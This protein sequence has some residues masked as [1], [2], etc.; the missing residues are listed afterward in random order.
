MTEQLP[1]KPEEN[2]AAL[3]LPAGDL[4]PAKSLQAPKLF[5]LVRDHGA[6]V[7]QVIDQELKDCAFALD[8]E[9][10]DR[11]RRI[12]TQ[13]LVEV[14]SHDTLVDIVR[15]IRKI[16]KGEIKLYNSFNIEKIR[17]AVT[18]S[19]EETAA[20]REKFHRDRTEQT[21]EANMEVTGQLIRQDEIR[22]DKSEREKF[23]QYRL[24]QAEKIR[25]QRKENDDKGKRSTD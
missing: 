5:Q 13:D 16:R 1:Q 14:Y 20:S 2:Q 8:F 15:G 19:L 24:K 25:K 21:F 12:I 22:K 9:M 7:F 6:Q 17:E 11:R 3:I 18:L 10:P 4:S 23:R